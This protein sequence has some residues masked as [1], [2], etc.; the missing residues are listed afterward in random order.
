MRRRRKRIKNIDKLRNI[1][2]N[3]NEKRE[4]Q[5]VKMNKK[6]NEIEKK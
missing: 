2:G 3:A 1:D 6:R 4:K 5:K